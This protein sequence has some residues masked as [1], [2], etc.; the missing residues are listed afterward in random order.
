MNGNLSCISASID[1]C[2]YPILFLEYI[3]Q[4]L[5]GEVQEQA[6]IHPLLRFVL[7]AMLSISWSYLNW[8]GLD[9]VGSMSVAICIIAMSPFVIWTILS[10]T[11]VEPSRWFVEPNVS[12]TE[13]MEISNYDLGG[14]LFPYA[15][16][17]GVLLRPALNNLFWNFNSYDGAAAFSEEVGKN[18][19]RVIPKAMNIS[20]LLVTLGY[21]IPLSI[22]LGVSTAKQNE[23]VDGF[24]A[25]VAAEAHGTWLGSWVVFGAAMSNLGLYLGEL[26]CNTFRVYG[27]AR[28]RLLPTFLGKRS[29]HGTPTNAIVLAT[30]VVIAFSFAPLDKLVELLNFNYSL[31]LLMEFAAFLKL[32]M[33]KPDGKS[34]YTLKDGAYIALCFD[35][36]QHFVEFLAVRNGPLYIGIAS[37]LVLKCTDLT[38]YL[39]IHLAASCSS[40]LPFARHALLFFWLATLLC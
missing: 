35:H 24:M 19:E 3:L 12:A 17:G 29:R 25:S 8:T 9:I 1:N 11:Q 7:L 33:T 20:W 6:Y 27:M 30:L 37:T 39:W 14:G 10:L 40:L 16:V 21:L 5:P 2:V 34:I 22:A 4:I 28:R 32:R 15:Q 38:E 26:S 13:Y 31:A 36:T 18:R 23:W